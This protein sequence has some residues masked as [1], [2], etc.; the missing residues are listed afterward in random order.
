MTGL[1]E[2]L[3]VLCQKIRS[4][5]HFDVKSNKKGTLSEQKSKLNFFFLNF[6]MISGLSIRSFYFSIAFAMFKSVY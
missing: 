6:I 1:L 5:F 3:L 2:E 4:S